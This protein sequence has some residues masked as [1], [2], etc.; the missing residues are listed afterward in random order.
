MEAFLCSFITL[1]N[2]FKPEICLI[3]NK[4]NSNMD[5]T[6]IHFECQIHEKSQLL[7]FKNIA[8]KLYLTFRCSN[9]LDIYLCSNVYIKKLYLTTFKIVFL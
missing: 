5:E 9:I 7:E 2:Y 3:M 8:L 4:D 6:S 1:I